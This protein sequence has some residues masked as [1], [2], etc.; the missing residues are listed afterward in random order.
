MQG[1]DHLSQGLSRSKKN[2]STRLNFWGWRIYICFFHRKKCPKKR[3]FWLTFHGPILPAIAE[4]WV[5]SNFMFFV[6]FGVFCSMFF[7]KIRSY[8]Q[9]KVCIMHFP[10]WSRVEPFQPH[11][12]AFGDFRDFTLCWLVEL[13]KAFDDSDFNKDGYLDKEERIERMSH[14]IFLGKVKKNLSG[15]WFMCGSPNSLSFGINSFHLE[16][17]GNT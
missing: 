12:G 14:R 5:T 17:D 9:G 13:R 1:C 16:Y 7:L 6:V 2:N 11:L 3:F 15:W 4:K 8:V 10:H